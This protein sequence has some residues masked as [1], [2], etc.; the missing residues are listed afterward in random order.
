M[1]IS[2][3]LHDII[4]NK[5]HRNVSK[6]ENPRRKYVQ[7]LVPKAHCDPLILIFDSTMSCDFF[8]IRRKNHPSRH[9]A[10]L[11]SFFETANVDVIGNAS[12]L[13]ISVDF[14]NV[15][16]SL[17]VLLIWLSFGY[18]HIMETFTYRHFTIYHHQLTQC[19]MPLWYFN[20]SVSRICYNIRINWTA[21]E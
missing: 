11:L 15:K 17:I 1:L 21:S 8:S 18:I 2:V 6:E 10:I 13:I 9:L 14:R 4:D 5:I 7:Y 12:K 16:L 19:P 20:K 3:C